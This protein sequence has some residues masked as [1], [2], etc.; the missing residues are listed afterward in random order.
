MPSPSSSL[1]SDTSPIVGPFHWMYCSILIM[2]MAYICEVGRCDAWVIQWDFSAVCHG[3]MSG[4]MSAEKI[5]VTLRI[6]GSTPAE[7]TTERINTHIE[8]QYNKVKFVTE[9]WEPKIWSGKIY[10][11]V[12]RIHSVTGAILSQYYVASYKMALNVKYYRAAL[13]KCRLLKALYK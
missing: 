10:S 11:S 3:V 6:S 5:S 1:L 12:K 4:V 2:D 8:I 7:T 9:V 13:W